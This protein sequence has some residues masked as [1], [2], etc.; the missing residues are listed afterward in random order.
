[1]T[2]TIESYAATMK[3]NNKLEKNATTIEFTKFINLNQQKQLNE[4]KKNKIL[5]YKIKKKIEKVN[6]KTLFIKKLIK[7]IMRV[8]KHKKNVLII[9]RLFN[10]NIKILT[11]S[12]KTKQKLK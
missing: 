9:R 7:R 8:E 6:I 3:T 10:K 1:M 5:I 11:R 12:T 4:L 2:T